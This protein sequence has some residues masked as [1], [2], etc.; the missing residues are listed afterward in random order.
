MW[1]ALLP[2]ALLAS[3][4]WAE[5]PATRAPQQSPVPSA[6][7]A[8]AIALA[9]ER[10]QLIYAYDQAAWH[11]T[12]DFRARSLET[13]ER[14]G[15]WIVTG[16]PVRTV[17]TFFDRTPGAPKPLYTATFEN[18]RLAS[19]AL[20][21]PDAPPLAGAELDL[22][23]ALVVAREAAAKLTFCANAP[24]NT[25]VLPARQPGGPVLVYLL[26]PQTQA[27]AVPAGGHYRLEIAADGKVSATR[28]FSKACLDLPLKP[29]EGEV[30]GLF[31]NHFLD[32]TPTE[33]HVF[34]ALSV[35]KPLFVSTASNDSVWV[36]SGA[37]IRLVER[38]ARAPR[39]G[40]MANEALARALDDAIDRARQ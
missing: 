33:I 38:D 24:A 5:Q 23:K 31:I 20:A 21:P 16:T 34:T 9:I 37:G 10:G 35:G 15:G 27:D 32:P 6:A 30:V 40:E 36:V 17:L 14:S 28:P 29:A 11:G 7:E 3:P 18:G 2:L 19:S 26:T 12:D 13:L 25:V 4:G 1:R 22:V 39:T 8:Q